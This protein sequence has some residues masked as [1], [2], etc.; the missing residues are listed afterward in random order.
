MEKE[1]YI[2]YFVNRGWSKKQATEKWEKDCIF[3]KKLNA[4]DSVVDYSQQE[5]WYLI[6]IMEQR[7]MTLEL[8]KEFLEEVKAGTNGDCWN[9]HSLE[10]EYKK[11]KANKTTNY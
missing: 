10:S 1:K 9:I 5:L 7:E 4:I 6:K 11:A 8:A 2:E 3:L